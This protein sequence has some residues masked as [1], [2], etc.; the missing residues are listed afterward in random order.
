MTAVVTMGGGSIVGVR[1]VLEVLRRHV[2]A[3]VVAVLVCGTG[4]LTASLLATPGYTATA[5]LFFSMQNASSAGDLVEGGNFTRDQM[6]SFATLVTTPAVLEPVIDELDLRID[7]PDL[8]GRVEAVT[9]NGTVFLEVTV[10]DR[11]PE[12]AADVANAVAAQLIEVVDDVAPADTEGRAT[13]RAT[14]VTPAAAPESASSPDTRVNLAAGLLAGLA[15]GVLYALA[16]EAL[17]TRV[18]DVHRVEALTDAPVLGR[19]A[20]AG[21]R[22]PDLVVADAPH[23]PQAELFRQLRTNLDFSRAEGEPFSVAVTSALPGEGKSTVAV[24]LALAWSEVCDRVLL[25]DADLR[26]P[27]V[28]ERLGLEGAAGLSTVLVGRADVEDV[29][30]PWGDSGLTVLTSGAVP[31]NP[32][33]LLDSP[34]MRELMADLE[35]RYD[36]VVVDSA[37]VL[38]VTDALLLS[39]CTRGTVVVVDSR[40]VRRH[41]LVE[42]LR[43]LAAVQTRLLGVVVNRLV[44]GK[45]VYGY[46][47]YGSAAP[48]ADVRGRRTAPAVDRGHPVPGE[49]AVAGA[50]GR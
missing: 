32:A 31:P 50:R 19:L 9:P 21:A 29:V 36:V 28:A 10:T 27:A 26:R 45:Q 33:Q 40:R 46:G 20:S 34:R 6:A 41:Q 13:V 4:A 14:T 17:D 25:V 3:M 5:G 22:V 12:L 8:A 47:S 23:S 2:V 35:G 24:N 7:V 48:A 18:R 42:A 11:S 1:G 39:R 43:Q 15:L 38:P 44:A 30:Q 16:R 37:P 49:R